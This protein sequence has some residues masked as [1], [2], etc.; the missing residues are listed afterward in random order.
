MTKRLTDAEKRNTEENHFIYNFTQDLKDLIDDI[1]MD[2]TYHVRTFPS[3]EEATK[4]R[5]TVYAILRSVR[6]YK[7]YKPWLGDKIWRIKSKTVQ[8]NIFS[9]SLWLKPSRYFD[10]GLRNSQDN[11]NRTTGKRSNQTKLLSWKQG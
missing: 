7:F 11:G 9:S 4:Y 1:P 5:G 10:E 3:N 8:G 6:A 2:G